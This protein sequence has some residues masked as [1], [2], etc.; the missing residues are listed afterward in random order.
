MTSDQQRNLVSPL[1]LSSIGMVLIYL[2]GDLL[3]IPD[4]YELAIM[5]DCIDG[6]SF[7]DCSSIH[8]GFRPPLMS[9]LA[10]PFG[11]EGIPLLSILSLSLTAAFMGKATKKYAVW[12]GVLALF[13]TQNYPIISD[14]RSF[15][16]CFVFGG[17]LMMTKEN[18]TYKQAFL[19]SILTG[20]GIWIRPEALLGILLFF[21]LAL[22]WH[23]KHRYWIGMGI[24]LPCVLWFV[25]ISYLAG[26]WVW[27]PRYWEGYMLES[28]GIM[29]KRL[30]M[31]LG[32]MGIYNTPMREIWMDSPLLPTSTTLEFSSYIDWMKQLI[33]RN[34]VLWVSGV[35]SFAYLLYHRMR[36][37]W[38][39]VGIFSINCIAAL[40][41][42]ARDPAF[43]ESNFLLS[44]LALI[45][46]LSLLCAHLFPSRI[47]LPCLLPIL[48][49]FVNPSH[50]IERGLEH[51]EEGLS[52][53]TWIQENS[54]Q[55]SVWVSSYENAP[56]IWLAKR[57]WKQW[58]D[59][60][61]P[62]Q[63]AHYR[64][65]TNLDVFDMGQELCPNQKLEVF[66]ESNNHEQPTWVTIY[67]C[68][69]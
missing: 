33:I 21:P 51:T 8:M 60:W 16:P 1:I 25:W 61:H 56:I 6:R 22:V 41:P 32:G 12:I 52:A 18:L 54:K 19:M 44:H 5:S 59:P 27:S 42:Q 30:M 28:W 29:P 36:I 34:W 11:W 68:K 2:L 50:E 40:L 46:A 62:L 13:C 31:Q 37:G 3:Y 57:D 24:F 43:F 10:W 15:L 14:A 69:P 48:V 38:I 55:N 66:F 9:I 26:T 4:G 53:I 20:L 64:V 35:I 23:F 67:S 63:E 49:A 7:V 47:L 65:T 17:W 45:C 39:L 58:E